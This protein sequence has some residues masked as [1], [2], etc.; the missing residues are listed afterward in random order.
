M[1]K[2]SILAIA[3]CMGATAFSQTLKVHC[4]AVTVAVPVAKAG[5][6]VYGAGGTDLTIMGKTYAVCA[7]DSITVDNSVVADSSVVVTYKNA[8]PL[9]LHFYR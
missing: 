7:I 1:K 9:P 4:G 5:D 3:L 6:M 2:I 8:A